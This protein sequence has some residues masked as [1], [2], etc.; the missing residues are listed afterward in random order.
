MNFTSNSRTF[1]RKSKKYN[2]VIFSEKSGCEQIYEEKAGSADRRNYSDQF[3][4]AISLS[5]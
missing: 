3:T 1:P 2:E 4:Y 5:T